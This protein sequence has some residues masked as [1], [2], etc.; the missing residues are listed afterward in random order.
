M[1]FVLTVGALG[2]SKVAYAVLPTGNG[3]NLKSQQVEHSKS[4]SLSSHRGLNNK[5]IK[6]KEVE[7]CR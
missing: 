3:S 6:L 7:V 4:T 1:P 5:F 2:S